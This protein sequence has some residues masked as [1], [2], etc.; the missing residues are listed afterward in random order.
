MF[1]RSLAFAACAL[2]STAAQARPEIEARAGAVDLGALGSATY[3][4]IGLRHHF[5]DTWSAYG[6]LD[7]TVSSS[8]N[9]DVKFTQVGAHAEA[10]RDFGRVRVTLQLGMVYTNGEVAGFNETDTAPAYGIKLRFKRVSVGWSQT[11]YANESIT[12]TSLIFHF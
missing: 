1:L 9:F 3:L 4:G 5:D 6:T 11:D 8:A 12:S 7:Q 10:G 2:L